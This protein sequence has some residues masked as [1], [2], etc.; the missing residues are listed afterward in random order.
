MA[1]AKETILS[2]AYRLLITKRG[3][4]TADYQLD[5]RTLTIYFNGSVLASWTVTG[6]K[7][8]D[9]DVKEVIDATK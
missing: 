9:A 7:I 6:L 3:R 8:R 2:A 5:D 1:D 4:G